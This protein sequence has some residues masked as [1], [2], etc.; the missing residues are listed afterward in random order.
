VLQSNFASAPTM[1]VRPASM[2]EHHQTSG[3]GEE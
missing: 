2:K 1:A 3:L